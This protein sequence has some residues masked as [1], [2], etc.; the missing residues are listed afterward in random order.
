MSEGKAG[1]ILRQ[2]DPHML[3]DLEMVVTA[4]G[5]RWVTRKTKLGPLYIQG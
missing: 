5:S 1:R 2:G 4:V 3:K